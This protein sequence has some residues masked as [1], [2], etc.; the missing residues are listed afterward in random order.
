MSLKTKDGCGKLNGE[1]GMYLKI[2][3]IRADSGNVVENT[4]S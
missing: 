2:K 4:G 3:E 1:A